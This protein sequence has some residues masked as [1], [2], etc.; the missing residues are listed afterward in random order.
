MPN[1]IV[2]E[3]G[4]QNGTTNE[5]VKVIEAQHHKVAVEPNKQVEDTP[6]RVT[7]PSVINPVIYPQQTTNV[8]PVVAST[9][10]AVVDPP[11]NINNNL[12]PPVQTDTQHINKKIDTGGNR[13][14]STSPIGQH[15]YKKQRTNM[16]KFKWQVKLSG[17]WEN[18]SAD[19]NAQLTQAYMSGLKHCSY[20]LRGNDYQYNFETMEQV[21]VASGKRRQIRPPPGLKP[22]AAPVVP[23]GPTVCVL[24]PQSAK[25]GDVLHIPHPNN[26]ALMMQVAVPADAYPGAQLL[27]PVPPADQVAAAAPAPDQPASTDPAQADTATTDK[28]TKNGSDMTGGMAHGAAIGAAGMAVMA[29]GVAAAVIATDSGDAIADVAMAGAD[30]IGQFAGEAGNFVMNLF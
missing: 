30:E 26:T 2:V 5:T 14:P 19:E 3:L 16:S 12:Y 8:T 1:S 25:P 28:D 27:V 24:V 7:T 9:P 23:P 6:S 22:P 15:N 4:P 18:Y 10:A 11:T 17:S 13:P 20:R 29:G 21:N